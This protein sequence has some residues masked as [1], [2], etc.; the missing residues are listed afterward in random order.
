MPAR[1]N[2]TRSQIDS[3][4]TE[5]D[6]LRADI[7]ASLGAKDARY[8]RQIVRIQRATEAAGRAML[9]FGLDPVSWIVGVGALATSKVL[10][11]MEIGHNVLHGQ[12]DWMNDPSLESTTYEW[13]ITNAPEDWKRSHNLRHH[14]WTNVLGLDE[15]FGYNIFRLTGEQRWTPS[16]A[17]QLLWNATLSLTFQWGIGSQETG[18]HNWLCGK[19]AITEMVERGH[20]FFQKAGRQ[21]F[22][23]YILFPLLT[24][25]NAMRV[26]TGNLVANA[27]RNVWAHTIIFCGHFT[28]NVYTFTIEEIEGETRGDWYLRQILGSSNIEGGRV[29]DILTGHLSYQIEHHVFPDLPSSRY[30]EIA[31]RL[32]EICKRYGIPYNTGS[33]GRQYGEMLRRMWT[34]SKP[35]PAPV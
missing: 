23:D 13:D 17:L 27:A 7:I 8:I 4:Q 15:D 5:F 3:L 26:F 31:E 16:H 24:P 2:L 20:P 29:F 32:R 9:A 30:P 25:W 28:Q 35:T 6:K 14:T 10:E 19:G 1:P 11:N 34:Y 22:K 21:L 18:V 12:W 33:L